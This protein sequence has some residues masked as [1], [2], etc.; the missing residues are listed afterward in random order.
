MSPSPLPYDNSIY[1]FQ[2]S[3]YNPGDICWVPKPDKVDPALLA[4]YSIPEGA[5]GHPILIFSSPDMGESYFAFIVSITYH[6]SKAPD[7]QNCCD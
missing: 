5:L 4:T 3:S 7:T 6:V 1:G 2:P